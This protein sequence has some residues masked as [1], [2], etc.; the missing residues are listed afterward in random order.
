MPLSKKIYTLLFILSLMLT[1]FISISTTKAKNERLYSVLSLHAERITTQMQWAVHA[2]DVL[3]EITLTTGGN[4]D[5]SN[6]NALAH[7]VGEGI[8]YITIQYA[9][10][11]IIKY[12]YPLD[13]NEKTI[14]HNLLTDKVTL[15]ESQ[16]AIVE[17]RFVVSGPFNLIQGMK[18]LAIRN[19]LYVHIEDSSV[20]WGFINIVLPVPDALKD[21]GIFED[22]GYQFRIS[23]LYQGEEILF[24]ETKEFKEAFAQSI[25]IKIGGN[26]WTLSMYVKNDKKEIMTT[27]ILLWA[28]FTL[29][30]TLIYYLMKKV[31]YKLERD[32]LTGA[33]NRRV[34]ESYIKPHSNMGGNHFA[35]LYIDLN[36]FKPIN[37]NLGHEIGDRLLIAYVKRIQANIKSDGLLFRIGG[38]EFVIIVEN[39]QIKNEI[40]EVMKRINTLSKERFMIQGHTISISASLGEA[41]Y[42]SEGEELK[43]L[44]T[45]ADERMY[46]AKKAYKEKNNLK[47]RK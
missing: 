25:P 15:T 27:G 46:A 19:P 7:A 47:V 18:G 26:I 17:N 31:E 45:V 40:Q 11:G 39:I 3:K 13:G 1:V 33:F 16:L 42:P 38:D 43:A 22:L 37:D 24:T 2:T 34:L 29:I 35:L 36:E 32:P 44:L 6:F 23:A 9:P 10:E 5:Q 28:A 4:L 14:G 30:A 12:A 20:F 8:E 21:T 41:L